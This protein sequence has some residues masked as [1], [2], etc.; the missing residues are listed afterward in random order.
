MASTVR[1][2]ISVSVDGY[3][4]GPDPDLEQPLGRG[5]ERLHDWVVGSASWRESHGK[6]GGEHNQD[7]RIVERQLARTGA[8]V[9]GR[10]M[11][12][13]G[14]GPW[15]D[16]PMARGWWGDEPPFRAPVFVLTHHER[17]PLPMQGGTTF[18]FV[19]EGIEAAIEQARAAA[20]DRDVQVSGG[21]EAAREALRAG[22]LDEL[23]L[24]VAPVLLGGGAPLF[25]GGGP[26]L[27]IAEV[28]G[29]PMVTH[30]TYRVRTGS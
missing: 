26:D 3:V 27:E 25:E 28:V 8:F 1:L 18:T 5:G 13:G 12:S 21:G 22:L 19:T 9:M 23:C 29:S 30:V 6:E 7:S 24:H 14:E 11:F 20:G 15:E 4:A 17:E 16:D 10:K 2:D